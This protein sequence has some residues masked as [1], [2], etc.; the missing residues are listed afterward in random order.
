LAVAIGAF[1]AHGLKSRVS[2]NML[3]V[4]EV[5]NLV[6]VDNFWGE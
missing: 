5:L 3:Q 2:E 4:F 1:G 6:V